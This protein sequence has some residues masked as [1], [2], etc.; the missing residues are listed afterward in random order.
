MLQRRGIFVS[1]WMERCQHQERPEET[2][3][4]GDRTS[5]GAGAGNS[6]DCELPTPAFHP[7]QL[8]WTPGVV[9]SAAAPTMSRAKPDKA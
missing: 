5:C 6:Y 9:L 2:G 1:T 8:S 4:T 3:K 7:D